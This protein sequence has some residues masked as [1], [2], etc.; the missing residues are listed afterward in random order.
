M[1]L[2][3][4]PGQAQGAR[5][6]PPAALLC[7]KE[8]PPPCNEEPS[9]PGNAAGSC[10]QA[11]GLSHLWSPALTPHSTEGLGPAAGTR[12]VPDSPA[13]LLWGELAGKLWLGS[14]SWE[15]PAGKLQLGS[16]GWEAPVGKLWL[17]R[18]PVGWGLSS[19]SAVQ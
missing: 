4:K 9:E 3:Q 1:P 18:S 10:K 13:L 19:A 15:A 6:P 11:D 5:Q 14:S 16:F 2:A 17:P 12:S 7:S 8:L